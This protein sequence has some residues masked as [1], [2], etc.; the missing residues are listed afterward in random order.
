MSGGSALVLRGHPSPSPLQ[1]YEPGSRSHPGR[2]VASLCGR[3][4]VA[5]RSRLRP[6]RVVP[7]DGIRAR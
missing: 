4:G 7:P 6:A 5:P 1:Q 2:A 3:G